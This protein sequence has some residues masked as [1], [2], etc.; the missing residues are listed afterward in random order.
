MERFHETSRREKCPVCGHAGWCIVSNDGGT[1][2]CRRTMSDRPASG[3][4][5]IHVLK[6]EIRPVRRVAAP[7]RP[8]SRAFDA[9]RVYA[10]FRAEMANVPGAFYRCCEDLW[11]DPSAVRRMNVGLSRFHHAWAFPMR[12]GFGRVV[13]IRLREIGGSCKWTV[14]GSR[15]GLFYDP[16]IAPNE[17]VSKGLRGREIVV[18]EGPTDCIAAYEIGLPCVGRSSCGTGAGHLRDLCAR[19]RVDR[20]TV[21]SDDD[22][23][24]AGAARQTWRPGIDGARRLARELGRM[25]RIVLPPFGKDLRDWVYGGDEG[26]DGEKFNRVAELQPWFLP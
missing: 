16:D 18:C 23:A 3:G 7:V 12:D 6:A 24:K 8:K 14:P 20:V 1:C 9:E 11:L 25:C 19:L 13:G 21:V 22:G 4:G 2:I 17:T 26:V 15:D 5:W 10:G